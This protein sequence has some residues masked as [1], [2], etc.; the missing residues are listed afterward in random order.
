MFR[1]FTS[2]NRELGYS[3]S[4]GVV[5]VPPLYIEEVTE[6]WRNF[7]ATNRTLEIPS[8]ENYA[9]CEGCIAIICKLK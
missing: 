8:W 3:L 5:T 9:K 7:Q 1:R 2:V 6:N 4:F